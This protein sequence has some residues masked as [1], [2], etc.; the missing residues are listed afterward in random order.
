MFCCQLLF[1]DSWV[2]KVWLDWQLPQWEQCHHQTECLQRNTDLKE[3]GYAPTCKNSLCVLF[4]NTAWIHCCFPAWSHFSWNLYAHCCYCF[5]VCFFSV[6][7]ASCSELSS[8]IEL[9]WYLYYMCVHICN[10]L[11]NSKS[12]ML[13]AGPIMIAHHNIKNSVGALVNDI[14]LKYQE[15]YVDWWPE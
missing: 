7:S 11:E 9:H 10:I 2:M 13:P 4:T 14:I 12:G 8:C 5:F 15:K 1:H 6:T 3:C